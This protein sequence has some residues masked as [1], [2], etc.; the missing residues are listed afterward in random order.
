MPLRSRTNK[1]RGLIT[2]KQ[3]SRLRSSIRQRADLPKRR[4]CSRQH[5]RASL[6]LRTFRRLQKRKRS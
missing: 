4:P 2:S 6:Q 1:E 3:R 5:S